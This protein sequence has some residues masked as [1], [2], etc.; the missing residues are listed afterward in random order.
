MECGISTPPSAPAERVAAAVVEIGAA[1]IEVVAI[2]DGSAVGDV[3]VMVINH[4]P[5]VPVISP[6]MPAPP[7]SSEEA[8]SKSHTEVD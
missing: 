1:V 2:D 3:S 6:M 5:T 8:D 4:S 7:K